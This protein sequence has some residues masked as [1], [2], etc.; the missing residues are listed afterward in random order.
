MSLRRYLYLWIWSITFQK[1]QDVIY[2]FLPYWHLVLDNVRDGRNYMNKNMTFCID[3]PRFWCTM[4]LGNENNKLEKPTISVE[5][6]IF[7]EI[8]TLRLKRTFQKYRRSVRFWENGHS[9][10]FAVALHAFFSFLFFLFQ[11]GVLPLLSKSLEQKK[12][13]KF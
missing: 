4:K 12:G 2:I 1:C 8:S 5:V 11:S 9:V 6:E 3:Y 7:L 13:R 10:N